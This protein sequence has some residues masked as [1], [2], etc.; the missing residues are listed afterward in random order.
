MCQFDVTDAPQGRVAGSGSGAVGR[1]GSLGWVRMR[2]A[3]TVLT[4]TQKSAHKTVTGCL[5]AFDDKVA[6]IGIVGVFML[7][8]D[9]RRWAMRRAGALTRRAA[10][11]SR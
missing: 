9:L 5:V 8:P 7:Q 6:T 1:V 2:S 11:T 4:R 3:C 10:F